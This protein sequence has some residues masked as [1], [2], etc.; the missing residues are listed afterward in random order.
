[1]PCIESGLPVTQA[2][3]SSEGVELRGVERLEGVGDPAHLALTRSVV[4]RRYV[5]GRSDQVLLG[6]LG[7]VAA[8][9]TLAE[10]LAT[11]M[12]VNAHA[13]LRSAEG[14]VHDRA[15]EGHEC[16]E[17][18]D[19]IPR[20]VHAEA[21]AALGGES[22]VAV[23]GAEALD[24]LDFAVVVAHRE[25]HLIHG[26]AALHLIQ[27]SSVEVG[28]TRT[29]LEVALDRAQEAFFVFRRHWVTSW[30]ERA[31]SSASRIRRTSLAVPA[32]SISSRRFSSSAMESR[33]VNSTTR[34]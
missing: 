1:M 23:L 21:D 5:D 26:V 7:G 28:V 14:H 13:A 31:G 2:K 12:R 27:E 19:L 33:S 32:R 4:G 10:A 6:K 18:H 29:A 3:A 20:H 9:D 25:V 16:G 11:A 8:R 30:L 17:G 22:V 34:E 24:D 15:L